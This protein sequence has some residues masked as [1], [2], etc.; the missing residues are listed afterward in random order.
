M[1]AWLVACLVDWFVARLVAWLVG[2]CFGAVLPV[3]HNM[4]SSTIRST[5]MVAAT[6]S[7][8]DGSYMLAA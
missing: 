4:V 2:W 3:R 5:L 6:T 1:L 8:H 7:L